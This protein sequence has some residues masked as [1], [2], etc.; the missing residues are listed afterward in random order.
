VRCRYSMR[1][2]EWRWDSRLFELCMRLRYREVNG[3]S[4][5][6]T[7][8]VPVYCKIGGVPKQIRSPVPSGA[9]FCTSGCTC[10]YLWRWSEPRRTLPIT[11]IPP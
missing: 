11:Y 5:D 7:S 1:L 8:Q 2:T 3:R 9:P 4:N 10:L 6:A